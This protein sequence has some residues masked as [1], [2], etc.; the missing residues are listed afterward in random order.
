M[1]YTANTIFTEEH[2]GKKVKWYLD[3]GTLMTGTICGLPN[4]DHVS[5][6]ADHKCEGWNWYVRGEAIL[7]V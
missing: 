5:V 3:D 7:F 6:L 2:I 4:E 1:N